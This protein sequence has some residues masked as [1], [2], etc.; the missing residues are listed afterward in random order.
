MYK[1]AFIS[2]AT[3]Y[4]SP[5]GDTNQLEETARELRKLGLQV[6][7][8]LASASIPYEQYDLLHFF[9]IIRPADILGHIRRARKPFVISTIFVEYGSMGSHGF[10]GRLARIIGNDALEYLKVWA[11]FWK[12]G[13]K[14]NS[15]RYLLKGHRASLREVA[16]KAA[17]L[18]PNSHSEYQRLAQTYDLDLPY[19]VIPNGINLDYVQK[20]YPEDPNYAGA[21]LCM[22]RIEARKNQLQLIRA[23][24]GTPLRLFIHG[25]PSPNN[26]AYYEQCLAEIN[27]QI[28]IGDWLEPEA[29]YR[30]YANAK[31]HVLPSYFETTGLSSLEA[32]AMGCQIVITDRGDTREYFEDYAWYCEPEEVES[33]RRAILNAY[34]QVRK[35]GLK[36]RILSRFTW[37]QAAQESL[38]AYQQILS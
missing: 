14:I 12:N 27:E 22:G 33:I 15:I 36:K 34:H 16:K 8:Y 38:K 4:S 13:E 9:N 17:L 2:R 23:I 10:A 19:R 21:V 25:K 20:E 11:R 32:A 3:L 37:A 6:D 29:L 7:I 1:L 26:Q 35:P 30:A 18:L 24:K 31:V 28:T 5:G